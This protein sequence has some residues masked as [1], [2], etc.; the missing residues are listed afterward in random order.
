VTSRCSSP[1]PRTTG[2]RASACRPP[3]RC[4]GHPRDHTGRPRRR[5]PHGVRPRA[6]GAARMPATDDSREGIAAVPKRCRPY[7]TGR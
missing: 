4:P 7:F 6:P 1:D 5:G 3:A 2:S